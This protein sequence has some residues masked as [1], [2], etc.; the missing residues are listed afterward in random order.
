MGVIGTPGHT[1]GS[2]SL[3]DVDTGLLVAGDSING[4]GAGGLLGP[5][6]QFSAD[7]ATATASVGTLAALMPT[8][9]AFGHGGPP[10]TDDVAA[11]L[12]A[13]AVG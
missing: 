4:D 6:D 9:A 3:F 10:V 5:N 12:E 13:L 11:R 1:P 7:M 8:T 2:I